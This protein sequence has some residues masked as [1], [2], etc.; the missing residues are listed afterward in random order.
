MMLA[1][2]YG[3]TDFGKVYATA[4]LASAFGS[5]FWSSFVASTLYEFHIEDEKS[6][7]CTGTSCY[8]TTFAVLG[9]A[10]FFGNALA[11]RLKQLSS[12]SK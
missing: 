4:T 12:P 9:V 10:C 7:E 8:Q 1:N 3:S 2:F 6:N 11:F 5:L